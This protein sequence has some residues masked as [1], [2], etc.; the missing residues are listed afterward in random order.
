MERPKRILPSDPFHPI[1]Q[2]A[3]RICENELHF[4]SEALDQAKDLYV[5]WLDLMGAGHIMST[6]VQKSANFLARLHM[7]VEIAR[8]SCSHDVR[9][10][11]INDGIFIVSPKKGEL[12]TVVRHTLILLAARFIGTP[13]PHDRCL[14]KGG[15]AFGP[16]YTGD[17]LISGI[18]MRRLRENP[19]FLE[20]VLFGPPVI[21]AYRSEPAAPPYGIAIHESARAFASQGESPF[22]MTHWLWWQGNDEAKPVPNTP[23]LAALRDCLAADL[24]KH[25]DWLERSLLYQGLTKEKITQWR[26][27]SQQHFAMG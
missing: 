6:S 23:P 14:M 7:A 5:C 19:E 9:L 21:Q 11:P 25:F 4:T 3:K 18:K 10:L 22:Q 27:M 8:K 12:M 2:Y 1:R 16:V 20:R 26:Q 24:D 17:Q 13:R 15:I